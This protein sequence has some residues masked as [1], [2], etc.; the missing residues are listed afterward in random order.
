[1]QIAS[2]LR[3][4]CGVFGKEG[5]RSKQMGHR[6]QLEVYY[7]LQLHVPASLCCTEMH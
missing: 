6:K 2:G 7:H 5:H 1:M 3:L 4:D